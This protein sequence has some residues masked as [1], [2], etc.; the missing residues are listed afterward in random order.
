MKTLDYEILII[1]LLFHD[2]LSISDCKFIPEMFDQANHYEY[3]QALLSG[4]VN[5]QT[6]SDI[7]QIFLTKRTLNIYSKDFLNAQL[8]TY[9]ALTI[10]EIFYKQSIDKIWSRKKFNDTNSN[11]LEEL[12]E[13]VESIKQILLDL[14]KKVDKKNP[15]DSY[16]ENLLLTKSRLE[17][18][19]FT[20]GVIGLKSSLSQLDSIT[21][22]FKESEYTILAGRPSMG[23]TSLAL[24]IG[25]QNV[26]EGKNVFIL[27]IEMTAEQLI[28]RAIPKINNNLLLKNTVYAE[29]LDFKLDEVMAASIYLEKSG[30]EIEDFSEYNK[31]TII[32]IQKAIEKYFKA[33][34]YYPDLIILDYIQI[35]K[36]HLNRKDENQII[37]DISSILQRLAKRTKSSLIALSQLNRGLEDRPDKRPLNSD[38]RGSGSLEQDADIILFVYRE[39]IYLERSLIEKLKK[40]P[41]SQEI[42]ESL[43]NLQESDIDIAELIVSKNRNGA[44]G[45]ATSEFYK[46]A[47]SYVE[48]AS[49]F[50]M[51]EDLEAELENF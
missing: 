36:D 12:S 39:A 5:N 28:A 9:K 23:K 22:G 47:A 10:L 15:F 2:K 43:R 31:V 51:S 34:G 4:A 16:R 8:E 13:I 18:G 24:D 37:T 27:S 32:E 38:L 44:R 25:M 46:P 35:V 17:N 3:S 11:L 14:E 26:K 42:A 6:I 33:H 40:N 1:S 19:D 21:G 7:N 20:Q 29:N 49:I 45:T 50:T 48:S 30:L 41:G